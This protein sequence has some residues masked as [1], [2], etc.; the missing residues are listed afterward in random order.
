MEQKYVCPCGL[1]CK[2]C[3]F[4]KHELFDGAQKLRNQISES[5]LD[6]FLWIMSQKE[7]SSSVA[8]HLNTDSDEF[9][10]YFKSFSK[11]PIFLEVLDALCNIKCEKTCQEGGGCSMCGT[12]KEC[13]ILP[14][15]Q[16][17]GLKGCWECEKKASCE[18]LMFL[19]QNYGK[20][21]DSNFEIINEKGIPQLESRGNDYYEWQ[22]KKR[23]G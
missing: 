14:C 23:K 7:S 5:R 9:H 1:N 20:T 8:K 18:N 17:K 15:L 6:T 22:R 4:Y 10:S 13:S 2:D 12:T 21:I 16:E 19:R 3:M 11:M